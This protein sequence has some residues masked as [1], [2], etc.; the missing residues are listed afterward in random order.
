MGLLAVIILCFGVL[1]GCGDDKD[2]SPVSSAIEKR[3]PSYG[4][5]LNSTPYRLVL[6]F[7]E[8]NRFR[9][10]LEPGELI[11]LTRQKNRTHLVHVVVMDEGDR[12]ITD[13]VN[14]FYIDDYALDNQLRDFLCSW[15]VEFVSDSGF[16]NNFGS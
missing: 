14:S 10:T 2:M 7:E 16:Y 1:A 13:Y 11:S 15:Y 6:D 4:F 9:K 3:D 5:L 8:Q 12:A